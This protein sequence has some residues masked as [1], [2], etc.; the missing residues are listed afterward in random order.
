MPFDHLTG[1]EVD[2]AYEAADYLLAHS[3]QLRLEP[4]LRVKLDTL[5]ADLGAEQEDRRRIARQ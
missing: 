1:T 3:G 5:R 4:I 2:E